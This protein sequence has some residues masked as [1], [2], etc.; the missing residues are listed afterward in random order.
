MYR[1]FYKLITCVTQAIFPDSREEVIVRRLNGVFPLH[2]STHI[3]RAQKAEFKVIALSDYADYRVSALIHTLKY[4]H[5]KQSI[6]NISH[7]LGD[8]LLEEVASHAAM[9]GTGNLKIIPMPLSTGRMQQRGFNQIEIL[10]KT[11]VSKYPD[12]A[13]LIDTKSLIKEKETVPQ[14]H[15]TRKERLIN[16]RD[17]FNCSDL[18]NKHVLLIDDV[19]T[20]GATALE[21]GKVL[22]KA[23]AQNVNIITIARTL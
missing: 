2:I 15:L 4:K 3:L 5:N 22:I 12:M 16:V 8:Y 21:A 1:Y 14:T 17:A 18:Q 6:I 23:G 9:F 11:I 13:K 7:V 10:L 20:T 19:L